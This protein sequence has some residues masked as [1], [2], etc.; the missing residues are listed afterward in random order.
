MGTSNTAEERLEDGVSPAT[1]A[2]DNLLLDAARTSATAYALVAMSTGGRVQ[3][4]ET[5]GLHMADGG[6]PSPFANMAHLTRPVPETEIRRL[7]EALRTFYGSG[8]GGPYLLFAP[9]PTGDLS[10]HGLVLGGHPPL[11]IRPAGEA[12]PDKSRLT[13]D[14]VRD[15]DGLRTFEHTLA[16]AYPADDLLPFGSHQR[17]FGDGLLDSAWT[18]YLGCEDDRPV[19]TAAAFVSDQVVLVEGVSTRPESRGRGYG[20]AIT[21]AAAATRDDRPVVL[22]SSDPGRGVY[23]QLGF[24]PVLRFTLWIGVR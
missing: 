22:L 4:D 21:A 13:I 1:R 24:L 6:S 7:A 10:P 5:L 9:W 17:L 18:F 20:E 8:E 19:A 15:V 2:G 3:V 14:A 16:E 11:M 23:Q 12:P